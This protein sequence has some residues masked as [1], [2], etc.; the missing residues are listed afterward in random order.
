MLRATRLLRMK[1]Q[2]IWPIGDGH[3]TL[4]GASQYQRDRECRAWVQ[5][6]FA[7]WFRVRAAKVET[8]FRGW[9]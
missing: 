4:C 5:L 9:K 2:H 6:T 8:A 3:C 7:D 1:R